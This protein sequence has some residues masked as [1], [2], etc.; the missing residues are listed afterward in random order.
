MKQPAQIKPWLT[1]EELAVWVREAPS[2]DAY[3]RRLAIWLTYIGPFPAHQIATM[4]QVSKQAVWLWI[5]QYNKEGL[6]GLE[7]EG[8]GGRRWAYLSWAEEEALLRSFQQQA[9]KGE[10][11]TAKQVFPELQRILGKEISLAYVYRLFHRH[12]WRKVG[13]RP[14]HVK[15]NPQTQEEFKKTF[16]P[17]SKKL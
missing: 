2:R 12:G 17:S 5:G 3:Q 7:R 9:A 1:P 11:I 16:S 8:R 15:A 14:R 4:L 13:P 10:I 6:E